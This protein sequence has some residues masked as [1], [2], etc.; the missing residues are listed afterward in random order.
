MNGSFL[1][2]FITDEIEEE[3]VAVNSNVCL[4]DGSA[5]RMVPKS[6]SNPPEDIYFREAPNKI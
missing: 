5:E 3:L 2:V 1:Q 4:E 6:S